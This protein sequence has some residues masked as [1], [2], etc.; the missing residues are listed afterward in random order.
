MVEIC[1]V[2]SSELGNITYMQD[3]KYGW[4]MLCDNCHLGI[5]L[6]A[7]KMLIEKKEEF[8]L[9]FQ[10]AKLNEM[11]EK[12]SLTCIKVDDIKLTNEVTELLCKLLKKVI[13][14]T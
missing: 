14:K 1:S 13:C 3:I 4:V 6:Y 5:S 7:N 10:H 2:C 9:K 11:L 12:K 8:Y